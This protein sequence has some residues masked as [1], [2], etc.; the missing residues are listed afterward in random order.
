MSKNLGS[1]LNRIDVS[2][3]LLAA[4]GITPEV[5]PLALS[6]PVSLGS[7][8]FNLLTSSRRTCRNRSPLSPPQPADPPESRAVDILTP[9]ILRP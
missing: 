9:V 5:S 3:G 6:L 8:G 1:G 2:F 4:V 7:G